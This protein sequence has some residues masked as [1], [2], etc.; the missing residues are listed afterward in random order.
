MKKMRPTNLYGTRIPR[1]N[2]APDY[3]SDS[4]FAE[5]TQKGYIRAEQFLRVVEDLMN[6]TY[7]I[8]IVNVY[9]KTVAALVNFFGRL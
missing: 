4:V 1:T 2:C 9:T 8:M 6:Y 5:H 7:R 3:K